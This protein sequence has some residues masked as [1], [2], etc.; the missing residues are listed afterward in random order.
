MKKTNKSY[1]A[2]LIIVLV[3]PV[4]VFAMGSTNYRINDDVIGAGGNNVGGSTNYNLY[5]TVGE[6]V[7]GDSTS[8]SY[9]MHAGFWTSLTTSIALQVDAS[10]VNL[11]SFIPENPATGQSNLTVT[12]DAWGGYDLLINDNK[13]LTHTDATTTIANY[14]CDISAPC[15]WSGVGLGFAV[16]SGTSV[17]AKWGSDPTYKYAA[18]PLSA[19]LFHEKW[20]FTG[21]TGDTTTVGYQVDVPITQRSGTY[22][23]TV[24]YT[25]MAKL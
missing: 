7:I 25:A 2:V 24:T 12:T 15:L 21:G 11:G 23:N 20:G 16:K 8:S 22:S 1:L 5:D 17:E 18:I 13:A 9:V 4:A 6:P 3:F 10:T 19:T 14:S